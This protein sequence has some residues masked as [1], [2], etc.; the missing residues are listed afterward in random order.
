MN[1]DS[2]IK[3]PFL[4]PQGTLQHGALYVQRAA[5]SALYSTL[6]AGEYG[7]VLAP[8]QIGKSSLTIWVARRLA[9]VGIRPVHIDLTQIGRS[10]D[11][12]PLS[13]WYYGLI[14]ELAS[15]L[16]LSDPQPIFYGHYGALSPVQR[17]RRYLC[18]VVL[19]QIA[20]PVVIFIDEI[21]YVRSLPTVIDTD[22]FFA[23]LRGLYNERARNSHYKRLAFCLVGV[24]APVDLIKNAVITPFNIGATVRLE[25][26]RRDELAPFVAHLAPLGGD[27]EKWLDEIFHWTHGHPHLTQLLCVRLLQKRPTG[28]VKE[29]VAGCVKRHFLLNGR[30]GLDNLTYAEKRMD[31]PYNAERKRDLMGLYRR[32]LLAEK[33]L[34]EGGDPL[35]AEL[36][37]C[38]LAAAREQDGIRVLVVRNTIVERIFDLSWVR[39]KEGQRKLGT[40]SQRWLETSR[41]AAMLLRGEDLEEA[42][43]W[44][45][46]HPDELSLIENDFLRASLEVAGEERAEKAAFLARE[47]AREREIEQ[48]RQ[49]AAAER[50][51]AE[52]EARSAR[53]LRRLAITLLFAFASAV[54]GGVIAWQQQR[55]AVKQEQIASNK[56]NEAQRAAEEAQTARLKAEAEGRRAE[57]ASQNLASALKKEK[58]LLATEKKARE[59]EAT[60][61]REAQTNAQ[62]AQSTSKKYEVLANQM[63]GLAEENRQMAERERAAREKAERDLAELRQRLNDESAK[64]EL[65]AAKPGQKREAL[66]AAITALG[67]SMKASG[68]PS[69]QTRRSL[70][71]ALSVNWLAG[72]PQIEKKFFTELKTGSTANTLMDAA[73]SANGKLVLAASA[74]GTFYRWSMEGETRTPV[75]GE[76]PR[77]CALKL[78]PQRASLFVMRPDGTIRELGGPT[79]TALSSTALSSSNGP[80]PAFCPMALDEEGG[81]LTAVGRSG[82]IL[83]WELASG[84]QVTGFPRADFDVAGSATA[85]AVSSRARQVAIG[86]RDGGLLLCGLGAPLSCARVEGQRSTIRHLLYSHDGRHVA[87]VD[88]RG[89]I[90]LFSSAAD[91]HVALWSVTKNVAPI[92]SITFAS[93]DRLIITAHENGIGLVRGVAK[94]FS[95]AL[96][97]DDNVAMNHAE[98]DPQGIYAVTASDAEHASLWLPNLDEPKRQ[99]QSL[100]LALHPGN[101]NIA[102]FSAAGDR[103]LTAGQA[104]TARLYRIDHRSILDIACNILF[105]MDNRSKTYADHCP[106][107]GT[108]P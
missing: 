31:S 51:R 36:E 78:C 41:S 100:V 65:L 74:D 53:R 33:V 75:P 28:P 103:V 30:E 32:L 80:A 84:A 69:P 92:N 86:Y 35:Q 82:A 61:R 25:D 54:L 106:I 63:T 93:D 105:L 17:F 96:L 46:E 38:G 55:R 49:L 88:G 2:N 27:A 85:I 3:L 43:R 79:R 67:I 34:A 89:G 16:S 104:G 1:L 37:L 87:V 83:L 90:Y 52:G 40:Q 99:P 72:W 10:A 4:Q 29:A 70:F 76:A 8:R 21:E 20:E 102:R 77:P 24:A 23:A 62:L 18:D 56:T 22:E 68:T 47:A 91:R 59:G 101:V 7:H 42:Q 9:Q 64:A 94:G 19:K 6:V 60:A 50:T 71:A 66:E 44:A 48:A 15:Q 14:D 58:E 73:F 13:T 108:S 12:D 81:L 95:H 98:L 26:F 107:S 5:D 57:T 45:R 97:S 11:R 39:E